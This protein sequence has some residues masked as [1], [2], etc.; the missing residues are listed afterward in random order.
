M[1]DH[2]HM[3]LLVPDIAHRMVDVGGRKLSFSCRGTDAPTVVLETGLGAESDEWAAVEQGVAPCA[4]VFRYDRGGRGRSDRAP[5]PRTAHDMVH[6]LHVLLR[7]AA[8]PGPY[9]LV[10]HSFGG[11]LARLFTHMHRSEVAG[12]VLVDSLH[13]DQFEIFGPMF[14]PPAPNDPPGLQHARTFW[15]TGWRDPGSTAEGIDFQASIAQ[16][17]AIESFGDLPLCVLTASTF[18][19]QSLIPVDRRGPLQELWDEMQARFTR[20]SSN[21]Q[22]VYVS[23]SGHFLQREQPQVVVDAIAT[24][25]ASIRSRTQP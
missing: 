10:G 18:L 13:E 2:P 24:M 12:L 16:G 4:R 5:L 3:T 7:R 22:Q 9:L 20:L 19:N 21:V 6:D 14:P 11:L 1:N 15:T 17:R 25:L 8:V 23:S